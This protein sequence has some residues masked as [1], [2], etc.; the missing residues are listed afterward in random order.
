MALT[1]SL[2]LYF[3]KDILSGVFNNL[4]VW[5]IAFITT[6]SVFFKEFVYFLFEYFEDLKLKNINS[7]APEGER[8][9]KSDLPSILTKDKEPLGSNDKSI[10]DD[11]ANYVYDSDSATS[12]DSDLQEALAKSKKIS[13]GETSKTEA[14]SSKTGGE[15]SKTVAESS[16]TGA[17]FPRD[18]SPVRGEYIPSLV[19]EVDTFKED[20][21]KNGDVAEIKAIKLQ[22]EEGVQKYEKDG[23]PEDIKEKRIA[24]IN[25]K[26]RS[27]DNRLNELTNEPVENEGKGKG[28][29]KRS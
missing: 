17:E 14:E 3:L 8:G 18:F 24:S 6:V 22:L 4:N 10:L 26:I 1:I 21:D 13:Q 5:H 28:K 11:P 19:V 16:K 15:S 7:S 9:I 25:E 23:L 20:M 12:Q 29:A 27:C 2:G